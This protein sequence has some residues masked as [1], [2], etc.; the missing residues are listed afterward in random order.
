M[1]HH[2]KASQF[3]NSHNHEQCTIFLLEKLFDIED[4]LAKIENEVDK[5]KYKDE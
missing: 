4:R 3:W 5:L 2:K 1:D